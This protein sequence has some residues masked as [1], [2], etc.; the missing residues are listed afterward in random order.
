MVSDALST[1]LLVLGKEGLSLLRARFSDVSLL[2]VQAT[3]NDLAVTTVGDGFIC[4]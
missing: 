1:A 3:T 4:K 2:L